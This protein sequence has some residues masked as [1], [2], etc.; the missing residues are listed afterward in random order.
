MMW[1]HGAVAMTYAETNGRHTGA[2]RSDVS[3]AIA[4]V[5]ASGEFG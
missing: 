2:I 3:K 1:G 5:T 4:D